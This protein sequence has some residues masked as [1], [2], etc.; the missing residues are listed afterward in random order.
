MGYRPAIRMSQSCETSNH[1]WLRAASLS[2]K[3]SF[4]VLVRGVVRAYRARSTLLS[5]NRSLISNS[6]T[7]R[8]EQA[9]LGFELS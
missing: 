4:H 6:I 9:N 2:I 3:I 8:L 1:G 7:A 5:P